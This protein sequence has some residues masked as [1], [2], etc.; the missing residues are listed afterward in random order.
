M[1]CVVRPTVWRDKNNK[2]IKTVGLQKTFASK[3]F[4]DKVIIAES[5]MYAD[6]SD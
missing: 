6:N 2:Q 1:L 3:W 4:C 5:D